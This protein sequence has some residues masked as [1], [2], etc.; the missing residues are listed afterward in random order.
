MK[1]AGAV[2]GIVHK[3]ELDKIKQLIDILIKDTKLKRE[4]IDKQ[5]NIVNI[6]GS[7]LLADNINKIIESRCL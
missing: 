6:Y 4:I 3:N 7:E 5:K 2:F 1:K